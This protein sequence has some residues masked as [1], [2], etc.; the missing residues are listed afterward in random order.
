LVEAEGRLGQLRVRADHPSER[1]RRFGAIKSR[2]D[3]LIGMGLRDRER[4]RDDGETEAYGEPPAMS[5]AS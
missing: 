1:H 2:T 4:K 5:A 3:G